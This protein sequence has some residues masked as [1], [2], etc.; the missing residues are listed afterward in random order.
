M[1]Q[2]QYMENARINYETFRKKRHE[3]KN[4]YIV[5]ASLLEQS[6]YEKAKTYVEDNLNHTITKEIFIN[7][8]NSIFNAVVNNKAEIAKGLDIDIL[9]DTINDFNGIDD[10]DLCSLISNMFENAIEACR[11]TNENRQII[12]SARQEG[13]SYLF[14]IKNT[15]ENSVLKDNP[16]LNTTKKD[17]QYHG[18]GIKVIK[19]IAEKY[20][21]MVDFF[22]EDNMFICN[23]LLKI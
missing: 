9:V 19:D 2:L 15:I 23:V 10:I 4:H 12:F 22:E 18:L 5:I 17:K 20:N 3:F 1:Y 7:T 14:S 13:S 8:K 16:T 6:E 11:K 21:G